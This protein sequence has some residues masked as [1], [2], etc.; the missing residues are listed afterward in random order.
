MVLTKFQKFCGW[1]HSEDNADRLLTESALRHIQKHKPDFVFLC[2]VQTDEKGGHDNGW[3]SE[4]Y[5]KCIHDAIDNVKKVYEEAGDE[6]TI[7]REK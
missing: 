1:A 2:M 5:L 6:Y 7:K 3:M 4:A